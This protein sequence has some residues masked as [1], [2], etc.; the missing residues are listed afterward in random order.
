[1]ASLRVKEWPHR[2]RQKTAGSGFGPTLGD[3]RADGVVPKR[4]REEIVTRLLSMGFRSADNRCMVKKNKL[5]ST[6][7]YLNYEYLSVVAKLCGEP[8]DSIIDRMAERA[9]ADKKSAL[10][11]K[12]SVARPIKSVRAKSP[13]AA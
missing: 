9:A 6:I 3:T 1:M 2:C 10:K 11:K 4:S 7:A 13:R 12:S 8:V 5:A